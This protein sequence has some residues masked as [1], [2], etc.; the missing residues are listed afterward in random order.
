MTRRILTIDGGGLKGIFP[1]AFLAALEDA[2]GDRV[3]NH[4]D[5]IAGTSSGGIIALGLGMGLSGRE[6]VEFYE[7][8]GPVIFSGNPFLRGLRHFAFSKYSHEP[9]R[10]SLRDVLGDR[11]LGESKCRLL[12][13]TMNL[14][15]GQVHV[16]RTPHHT[17]LERDR[18]TRML[19]IAMA[20]VSAPTY[21]PIFTGQDGTPLIDGSMWAKN[22]VGLAVTEA[23]GMLDWPR[24]DIKVLSLG[25]TTAPLPVKWRRKLGFG[26]SYWGSRIADVFMKAQ[27]SSA[28]V[29][30][31][32]LVGYDNVV[33]VNPTVG[34]T[35]FRLDAIDKLPVLKNM[36]TEEAA[37]LLPLLKHQFLSDLVEPFEPCRPG[38]ANQDSMTGA[39]MAATGD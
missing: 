3:T 4:F 30:A 21:F 34:E 38:P 15:S 27:S 17:S 12:V 35:E 25:C 33:R 9:L 29:S 19:D 39:L 5:L 13:P 7:E 36:A 6:L 23:V 8:Q 10:D 26:R 31:K 24:D 37:R 2:I 28:L 11:R 16:Y 20:T 18:D 14:E 32:M 22:P 1:A